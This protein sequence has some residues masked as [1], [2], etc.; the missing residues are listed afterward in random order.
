MRPAHSAFPRICLAAGLMMLAIIWLGPLVST[1]R[2]SFA[3]HML[4]HMGVVAIAAPL[5]AL[6][7]SLRVEGRSHVGGSRGSGAIVSRPPTRLSP[8]MPSPPPPC[9]VGVAPHAIAEPV[10]RKR[11]P[12][13]ADRGRRG[14]GLRALRFSAPL[15]LPILASL[16]ELVV[17]WGWHAP[18]LRGLAERSYFATAA[19]Q[20]MFLVAGL[21][22][23][24]SCLAAGRGGDAAHAAAGA[25]GL[26]LTT[27]HMTLLGALLALSPRPLYGAGDVSCFGLVLSSAQDQQLGGVI[28][29]L[30][31]AAVY[32]AGGVYL[33]SRV[34]EA[35]HP[36]G[37][38]AK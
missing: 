10:M 16:L 2:D 26:L 12:E 18:F 4:A 6:S 32:L 22:L 1:W 19:E 14:S 21:F 7:F 37:E 24:T 29:L 8:A 15:H 31:G 5:L 11:S 33:L 9:G 20:A 30:I 25:F 38:A 35:P 3:V 17:V 27:V 23:W 36:R 13:G 34:L 28:M